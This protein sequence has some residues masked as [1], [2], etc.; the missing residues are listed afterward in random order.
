[1]KSRISPLTDDEI[2]ELLRESKPIT[3]DYEKWLTPPEKTKNPEH[4]HRQLSRKV[5]GENGNWFKVFS[6]ISKDDPQNFSVGLHLLKRDSEIGLVRVNGHHAGH[7]NR[8]KVGLSYEE[9][10]PNTCHIHKAQ[11]R[12]LAI[13]EKLI[14]IGYAEVT[15]RYMDFRTALEFFLSQYGFV[16]RN[17][18]KPFVF[19]AILKG[20]N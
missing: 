3:A 6:R 12:Y 14:S 5:E 16:S 19:T 4:R 9:I 18:G 8:I 17:S 2:E 10:P 20:M 15:D 1:M 7:R 11:A 13:D